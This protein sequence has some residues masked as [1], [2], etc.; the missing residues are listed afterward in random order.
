MKL[1]RYIL[2]ALAAFAFASCSD[3]VLPTPSVGIT[4]NG[5]TFTADISLNVAEMNVTSTRA[6]SDKPDY[7]N[8]KLYVLEFR[9]NPASTISD[10]DMIQQYAVT[11]ETPN[12]DG[13]IHFEITLNKTHEPRVLHFIAVPKDITLN[14]PYG[15]E[16]VV[17]PPIAVSAPTPAYWQR[18]I[19]PN[20]YAHY[21]GQTLEGDEQNSVLE[22]NTDTQAKLTHIPM[23]CN[24]A[25]ISVKDNVSNDDF[26]L[27]GF[28]V[29]NQPLHGYIA[30]W[31]A[32]ASSFPDFLNDDGEIK[33][34]DQI[35]QVYKGRTHE[36]DNPIIDGTE[37]Q[38][39]LDSKYLY[40]RTVTSLHNPFII[41]QGTKNGDETRYR[42]YKLDLGHALD[43]SAGDIENMFEYYDILRNFEYQVSINQ[44]DAEGY[45]SWEAAYYGVVYNNFSFD[46]NTKSMLNVS[47]GE[48][49]LWVDKTTIVVTNPSETTQTL[50]FRFAPDVNKNEY[51]NDEEN[52]KL[53]NYGTG[54]AI[55]ELISD[56]DDNGWRTI[57]FKT[58]NPSYDRKMQ[59]F[60]VYN[61]ASG[62]GRIITVIVRNPWEFTHTEVWGGTY[63]TLE[64][65]NAVA[66]AA[67]ATAATPVGTLWRE[68]WE[69]KVP[70]TAWSATS[71][72]SL[73]VT[74][75]IEDNIP[76]A[77]F[78]L[79]FIYESDLQN[80]TQN[81]IGDL[82]VQSGN[83]LFSS[84][85]TRIQYV[86]TITWADYNSNLSF[87]NPHGTIVTDAA[88]GSKYHVIRGR[89]STTL[90]I[91]EGA[92]TKI[93]VYNPYMHIANSDNRY[94]DVTF[95]GVN[96]GNNGQA[97]EFP[98]SNTTTPDN[99]ARVVHPQ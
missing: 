76:E 20:G 17:V 6:F 52:I 13:D 70:S 82:I 34:Y 53:I 7:G 49:M 63:N 75:R 50:R 92:S 15:L 4:D 38:F 14:I 1:F 29:C 33:N 5:D 43:K 64:Q 30:P 71:Q 24:F 61:T 54:E 35:D 83:S 31:D 44:V 60:I 95:T 40:E 18:V 27:T 90:T 86:K 94:F 10:C 74:F 11:N 55:D 99:A 47:N 42:Y 57:T 25:K 98:I 81:T 2:P 19:F 84:S 62:L 80:V 45:E 26:V 3:E 39:T 68:G 79:Q 69:G 58:V 85:N 46:I 65:F 22:L 9:Y 89:F 97:P 91:S 21:T 41:L 78:P 88:D 77:M 96:V 87:D 51:T 67:N 32:E 12:V 73:T 36:V 28:S 8:L 16:G 23:L 72:Q 56:V 48:S 66:T 59:E 37:N 93:R